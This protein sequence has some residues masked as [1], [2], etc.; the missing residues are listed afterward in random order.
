M[1]HLKLSQ[2]E[3]YLKLIILNEISHGTDLNIHDKIS[4]QE[5]WS[6]DYGIL[7][8]LDYNCHHCLTTAYFFLELS[9]DC[10]HVEEKSR[11]I[12]QVFQLQNT[13]DGKF[14]QLSSIAL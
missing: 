14:G 6:K 5:I 8:L 12:T 7:F 13:L 11:L 3:V 2:F 4:N 1:I 10:E 9:L